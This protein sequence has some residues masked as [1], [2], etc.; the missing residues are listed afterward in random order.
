[1]GG[2]VDGERGSA[3]LH[4]A[5]PAPSATAPHVGPLDGVRGIAILAVIAFHFAI[6]VAPGGAFGVDLFFAL[7]AFLITGMLLRERARHGRVDMPAFYVR[8]AARLFPALVIFL[9]L[10]AP[11]I[12]VFLG[13]AAG[14][15]LSTLAVAFYVSDFGVA[16]YFP[17][18]E[19]YGHTWSLAVEEQFYL[20]WPVTL[21]LLLRLR[22]RLILVGLAIFAGGVAVAT[23]MTSVVGVGANYFLPTGHLPALAAGVLAAFIAAQ[24]LTPR[25]TWIAGSPVAWGGLVALVLM[26][27]LPR[28]TWPQL[29][30]DLV[31]A[32]AL[33]LTVGL[34]LHAAS[35]ARSSMNWLL[36]N[37]VLRWFGTR[38]YGIYLYHTA[39]FWLFATGFTPFNRPV[40]TVLAVGLSLV[41]SELS[42]RYVERPFT[43]RG[44]TWSLARRQRVATISA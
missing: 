3:T 7:S 9:A 12:A 26:F 2:L 33:L 8:R 5:A 27:T 13:N 30:Q 43:E 10:I 17:I 6:E 19:P 22:A 36:S 23:V 37:P 25:T 15:P 21:L 28:A 44:R 16:G 35:G 32:A 40:D 4:S 38:S 1:M 34:L 18:V 41:I 14:I 39:L 24:G 31:P 20:V 29:L 11:P 42:F